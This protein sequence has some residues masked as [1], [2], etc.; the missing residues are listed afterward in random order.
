MTPAEA[1][2]RIVE[3]EAALKFAYRF[4]GK[5][6]RDDVKR[7]EARALIARALAR[8]PRYY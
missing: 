5:D 6:E 3:L 2:A 8:R 1:R 7:N 4:V